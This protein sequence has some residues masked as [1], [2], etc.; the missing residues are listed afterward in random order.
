MTNHARQNTFRVLGAVALEPQAD[1]ADQDDHDHYQDNYE[2]DDTWGW[3]K[4]LS[5][6]DITTCMSSASGVAERPGLS[7]KLG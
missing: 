5:L 2:A 1:H 6:T 7:S 4:E 3:R